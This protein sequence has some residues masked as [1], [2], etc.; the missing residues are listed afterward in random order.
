M[1]TAVLGAPIN[2]YYDITPIGV[3]LNRFSRDLGIL[4]NMLPFQTQ[5]LFYNWWLLLKVIIIT[6]WCLPWMTVV[7]FFVLIF[8]HRIQRYS[9]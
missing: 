6:C 3:S 1:V 8:I 7:L 9:V 5:Q 2:N 4:E